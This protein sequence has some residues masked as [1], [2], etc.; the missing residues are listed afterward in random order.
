M[1]DPFKEEIC[2]LLRRGP[3]AARGQGIRE[4]LEPLGCYGVQDGRRSLPARG[5]AAVVA[6]GRG[7]S[8]GRSTGR[9]EI[10]QL[11]LWRP[12]LGVSVGHGQTRRGWVVIACLGYTRAGAGV[13]VISTQSEDLLPLGR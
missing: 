6:R 13:L 1:L 7:R 4:L 5:A 2:R 8:S 10:C 12:R 3:E 11:D 9:G